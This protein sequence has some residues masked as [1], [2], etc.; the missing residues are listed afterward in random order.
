MHI[1]NCTLEQAKGALLFLLQNELN[2]NSVKE[3]NSKEQRLLY[4]SFTQALYKPMS[5]LYAFH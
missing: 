5:Y 4:F 3:T 1:V 2:A